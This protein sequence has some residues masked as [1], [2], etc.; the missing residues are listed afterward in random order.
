MKIDISAVVI[1][2]AFVAPGYFAY[3]TRNHF[4]SRSLAPKGPTE[5]FAGFVVVS[6]LIHCLLAL[7]VI[8]LG[9]VVGLAGIVL[10]QPPLWVFIW[11]DQFDFQAWLALHKS[12]GLGLLSTY[13]LLSCGLGYFAGLPLALLDLNWQGWPWRWIQSGKRGLWLRRRGVRGIF[14]E[15]PAIYGAL[16]P[17]LDADGRLKYVL[18]EAQLRDSKGFYT[19][20]VASYSISKDEDAHKLI[21]LRDASFRPDDASEYLAVRD[22]TI[23]LDLADIL[24]LRIQQIPQSS[25][26]QES[27]AAFPESNS[28][29]VKSPPQ[30]RKSTT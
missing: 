12:A 17:D 24:V 7:A 15:Y 22:K 8:A 20:Q 3:W 30:I 27:K 29:S 9:A 13:F 23:L 4:A 10:H 28:A 26:I 14:G 25:L 1:V 2:P 18:V 6:A 5:E 11:A 16:R 21:L 19:G